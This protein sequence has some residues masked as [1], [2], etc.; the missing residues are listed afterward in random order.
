MKSTV[1][2]GVHGHRAIVFLSPYIPTVDRAQWK[3]KVLPHWITKCKCLLYNRCTYPVYTWWIHALENR[4]I[5]CFWYP[6]ALTTETLLY[7][8]AA[9]QSHAFSL[10]QAH[11][12]TAGG[13]QR[14][15]SRAKSEPSLSTESVCVSTTKSIMEFTEH[16]AMLMVSC[17]HAGWKWNLIILYNIYNRKFTGF[18][19]LVILLALWTYKQ[20]LQS[21]KPNASCSFLRLLRYNYTSC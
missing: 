3:K 20:L 10:D 13:G 8:L 21:L 15:L 17:F 9:S 18:Q 12:V 14:S 19:I 1:N 4:V 5:H 2:G 16:E 11:E 7:T 6:H